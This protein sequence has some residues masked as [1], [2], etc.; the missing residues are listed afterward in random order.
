[1]AGRYLLDTNIVA[2]AVSGDQ[3][4][5]SRFTD[6]VELFAPV[7]VLGELLYGAMWSQ[8]REENLARIGS[9]LSAWPLLHVDAETAQRYGEIKAELRRLGRPILDNDLWIGAAAIL[10]G[11]TLLSR[12]AHFDSVP[13]LNVPSVPT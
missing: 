5:V 10:H 2:A 8:R 1:M 13:D 6:D 12:D 3:P 11:L 9:S 7:V 4:V